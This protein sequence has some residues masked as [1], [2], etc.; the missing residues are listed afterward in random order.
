MKILITGGAGVLGS[1]LTGLFLNLG[2]EVS[3]IDITRRE[4]AWR[5]FETSASINSFN[6]V[7]KSEQDISRSDLEG[8][9]LVFDCAI[10]FAD[11]PFGMES[12][13]NT[14]LSNIIPSLMILEGARK[15]ERRPVIVYPSS[16][17]ALY[18]LGRH[19]TINEEMPPVPTS[20]YG[21]TKA[22]AELLYRTYFTAYN[23]PT[24][25]TRTSSTF[26]P[27][28]RSDELPH[29]LMLYIL[30]NRKSFPLRSPKAQRL[31]TYS[32]DVL[33][34]YKAFINKLED[35][36]DIFLG[37][38]LH[39]GGNR[40]DMILKNLDFASMISRILGSNISIEEKEYEPGEIIDG[41]PVSF[42]FSAEETRKLLKWK[43]QWPLEDLLRKTIEWFK[44]NKF[45]YQL[46]ID[47]S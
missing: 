31:W 19:V 11:R 35:K 32:E 45:R 14:T 5:L 3:V 8:Y 36:R 43:P 16:F 13:L 44:S 38:V 24:V 25:I 9:D 30:N 47:E 15:L 41:D 37:K 34:F 33:S 29:K 7:W 26:G 22:T 40:N 17:N 39:L 4:E 18:G 23:V 27:K 2:H 6:Y 21:W 28:G 46:P 12:P 1:S 10:G 20:I 42:K